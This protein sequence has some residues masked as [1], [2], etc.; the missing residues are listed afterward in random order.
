MQLR[1]GPEPM[2]FSL[3][4]CTTTFPG[5]SDGKESACNVGDPG[6]TPGSG[7]SP[8]EENGNPLQY[9]CPAEWGHRELN[10]T[11]RL[12]IHSNFSQC[13]P[14]QNVRTALVETHFIDR[15]WAISEG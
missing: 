10:I 15:V 1:L 6:L 4:S 3:R 13:S 12:T 5:G 9:P 11:E 14:F 8:G 2:V 7:R